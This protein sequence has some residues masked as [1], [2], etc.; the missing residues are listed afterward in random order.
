[1]DLLFQ[2]PT[3]GLFYRVLYTPVH[4]KRESLTHHRFLT[5]A[6][7]LIEKYIKGRTMLNIDPALC[8]QSGLSR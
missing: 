1:M 3:Q 8:L 2:L 4:R 6:S 7:L 5:P